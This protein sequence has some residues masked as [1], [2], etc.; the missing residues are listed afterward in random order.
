MCG[1]QVHVFGDARLLAVG[2][3][4]LPQIALAEIRRQNLQVAA[5]VD[6]RQLPWLRT[7]AKTAA[8][9]AG[10]FTG[11]QA[12]AGHTRIGTA[13]ACRPSPAHARSFPRREREALQ[14][15]FR[16]CL[17]RAIEV[18]QPRLRAGIEFELER[19]IVLPRDPDAPRLPHDA[20]DAVCLAL[21]TA[22]IVG[23]EVPR[24]RSLPPLGV[25]RD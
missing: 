21:I 16:R 2:H 8:T 9:A 13:I 11:K 1:Q 5:A 15:P 23:L 20:A 18:E 25:D 14:R 17:L 7:T 10:Q 6:L 24:S 19:L 3:A 22:G 4:V 12:P